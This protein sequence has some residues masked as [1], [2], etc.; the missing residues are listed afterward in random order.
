MTEEYAIPG[1][2]TQ[3]ERPKFADLFRKMAD[4]IERNEGADFGGAV[5]V[6]PPS[7]S[8]VEILIL[9]SQ[10][11]AAQFWGTLDAT[12]KAALADL[13]DQSRNLQAYR[14]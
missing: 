6:V 13:E 4:A 3:P 14:R 2:E 1:Q 11:D 5:V 10:R 9:N 12:V 8:P 7:G